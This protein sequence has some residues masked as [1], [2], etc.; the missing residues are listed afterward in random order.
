MNDRHRTRSKAVAKY[1]H[2]KP[3]IHGKRDVSKNCGVA[4][5]K[6]SW[7]DGSAT[8]YYQKYCSKCVLMCEAGCMYGEVDDCEMQM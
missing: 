3:V 6:Q 7:I 8:R 1:L 2:R 5:Y 4:Y